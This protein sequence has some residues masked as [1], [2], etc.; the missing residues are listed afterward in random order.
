MKRPALFLDRD[1]VINVD[2]G[3]VHTPEEFQFIDG[4]FDLV[5]AA[6]R[7]GY[8][9][10]VVTNQA[11]I[12]RGYYSEAQ[13]HD[14]THWMRDR[15][16]EHGGQIDGV[17]FCP[18]HPEH[19][20]GEYCRESEFRKPAPGMLLKAQSELGIDLELSIF[21]GDKPS[22]MAA[23]R[24]AG[25]GTLLHFCGEYVADDTIVITRL[26]E[27]MRCLITPAK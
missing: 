5:S 9:V 13:F 10:V 8:L 20:I 14:L 16:V 6:N 22:D 3:Y 18:Y 19:G 11:G 7:S 25:V 2:H 15:F 24:A 21:I 23:G 27:A 12:A 17:Y 1:G 4:I 26:S